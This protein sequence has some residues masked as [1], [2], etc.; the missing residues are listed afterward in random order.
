MKV[1]GALLI[2]LLLALQSPQAQ[3]DALLQQAQK[4][5]DALFVTTASTSVVVPA[6]ADLQAAINSVTAGQTLLLA[7]G[8]TF[9]GNYTLPPKAGASA[10][11]LVTIRTNNSTVGSGRIAPTGTPLA[12]LVSPNTQ[13]VLATQPTAAFYL[14]QELDLGS[15]AGGSDLI[16]LGD[17]SAA[18]TNLAMVPHDLTLD[19]DYIHGDPINGQKR[20]V[21]LNSASTTISNSYIAN[22]KLAGQDTQAIETWNGPGPYTITNN[23]LEA[24]G[25]NFLA[26]GADPAIPNLVPS[27][28]TITHNVLAKPVAWM[29][30]NWQIKNLLELKNAAHV[31]VQNNDFQYIWAQAQTGYAWQITPRNQDGACPWC[32]VTDVTFDTNTIEHAAAVANLL[33]TDNIHPSQPLSLVTITNNTATDLDPVL[34]SL[35]AQ[36]AANGSGC[37]S[38]KTIQIQ[39]SGNGPPPAA[40]G[41]LHVTMDHN[42]WTGS[43]GASLYFVNTPQIGGVTYT[44]NVVPVCTYGIVFGQSSSTGGSPIPTAWTQWVSGGT[45]SN[46]S[47][48]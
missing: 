32:I 24:A 8:A 2:S 14:I 16:T 7:P 11:V 45:Y 47:T 10:S 39:V 30:L 17:G 15:V 20:G 25:E 6:G 4:A 3:I 44:N 23:Y 40:Q 9:T 18:Q 19:R 38:D 46:N 12:K 26:G 48:H 37:A 42:T 31:L 13:P 21:A 33:G 36:C 22:I 5:I 35:P 29:P 27:N 28:I 43:C 1:G 34:Y 41:P